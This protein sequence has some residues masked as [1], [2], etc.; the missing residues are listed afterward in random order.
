MNMNPGG[1]SASK[2]MRP[3]E[4][5]KPDGTFWTQHLTFQ[6]N[7]VL[8]FDC[9]FRNGD[10]TLP[11]LPAG[12]VVSAANARTKEL[13]NEPKG[14]RQVLMEQGRWADDM[15]RRCNRGI[16]EHTP[17]CCATGALLHTE[18]FSAVAPRLKEL[19]ESRGH[20]CLFLPKVCSCSACLADGPISSIVS[21]PRSSDV[22][23]S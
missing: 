19:I 15:V 12:S 10:K 4:H 23:L 18:A 2:L 16:K 9:T 14:M 20:I 22:G 1:K 8:R 3:I 21:W 5:M 17:S 11:K 13:L 6:E 7:D